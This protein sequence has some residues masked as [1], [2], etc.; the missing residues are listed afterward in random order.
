MVLENAA[1]DQHS[2]EGQERHSAWSRLSQRTDDKEFRTAWLEI[3]SG[4]V[5]ADK[6][7]CVLGPGDTGP[8]HRAAIWPERAIPDAALGEAIDMALAQ[9]RPIVKSGFVA[10]NAA[11]CAVASPVIDGKRL[12]GAVAL[13]LQVRAELDLRTV[14]HDI[15]W[16]LPALVQQIAARTGEEREAQAEQVRSA[17]ELLGNVL[18]QPQFQVACNSAVT[19]LA[20]ALDCDRVSLGFRRRTTTRVAA[21]SHSGNFV[22]KLEL[23]QQIS[24]TMDEAIDQRATIALPDHG[25][26]PLLITAAHERLASVLVE[27]GDIVTAGHLVA[28]LSSDI[29]RLTVRL[30][31]L[32]AEDF[33]TIDAMT[34]RLDYLQSQLDRQQSLVDRGVG[35]AQTLE[36]ALTEVATSKGQLDKARI[37]HQIA[38]QEL[39]RARAEL[40]QRRIVSPI[41]GVVTEVTLRQGEYLHPEAHVAT[42]VRLD[43]LH[44]EAFLPVADYR[45]LDV[46]DL[47]I[48]LPSPPIDGA[49]EARIIAKDSVFDLASGTFAVRL[50]MPNPQYE[51]PGGH[52]CTL[53]LSMKD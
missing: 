52:R 18:E 9:R 34:A 20:D 51:I 48:V 36:A 5:G 1:T 10:E 17:L 44:V 16:A 6:A 35:T 37:D 13:R 53:R 14:M 42:I 41:D 8:F 39:E 22:R 38:L 25:G 15:S 26:N 11:R 50:L 24:D 7:L 32:R 3:L 19:E 2:S 29:E 4:K 27:R 31:E 49:Y 40:D 28:E 43:P 30:L 23:I 46:G 12:I 47:G 21:M 45:H 33:S